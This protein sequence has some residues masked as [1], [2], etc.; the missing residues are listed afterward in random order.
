[1][2]LRFV[3]EILMVG[4][5]FV[6]LVPILF[7][8]LPNLNEKKNQRIFS[9]PCIE[10]LNLSEVPAVGSILVILVPTSFDNLPNLIAK[11]SPTYLSSPV[12][13]IYS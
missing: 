3:F 13:N 1:M 4:V 5:P 9:S 10:Y 7:A 2:V 11:I 12:I 8:N 6:I